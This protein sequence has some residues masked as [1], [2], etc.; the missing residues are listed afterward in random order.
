[1]SKKRQK[2]QLTGDLE[3]REF[4]N[5]TDFKSQTQRELHESILKNDIVF[6]AGLAGTGK[7][8]LSL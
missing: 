7:T 3:L 5:S 2:Q 6:C 1:M 4:I 8:F